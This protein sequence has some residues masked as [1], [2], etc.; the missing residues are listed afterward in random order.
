MWHVSSRS[1]VATL[2]TAIHLLLT[3]FLGD[4]RKGQSLCVEAITKDPTIDEDLERE[5]Q[6]TKTVISYT[7]CQYGALGVLTLPS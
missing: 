3:Y 4:G 6:E 7:S 5:M 2:R 1:G